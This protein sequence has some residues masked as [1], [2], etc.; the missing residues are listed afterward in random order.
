MLSNMQLFQMPNNHVERTAGSQLHYLRQGNWPPPLTCGV[1]A[2]RIILTCHTNHQ[3]MI[4]NL[5]L[6]S[7]SDTE[8][9]SRHGGNI[10]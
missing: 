9:E 1:R 7:E 2:A 6:M 10:S 3:R 5:V 8:Q 4:E